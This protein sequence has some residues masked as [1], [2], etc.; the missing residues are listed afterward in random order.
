MTALK[1]TFRAKW[2]V[3]IYLVIKITFVY[4]TNGTADAKLCKWMFVYA[5]ITKAGLAHNVAAAYP[6]DEG[7]ETKKTS[8]AGQSDHR[9]QLDRHICPCSV[10][11]CIKAL[12][13]YRRITL[14]EKRY[15]RISSKYTFRFIIYLNVIFDKTFHMAFCTIFQSLY[16]I[17]TSVNT[18]LSGYL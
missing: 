13:E 16:F 8:V 18:F 7:S 6:F 9:C 12:G 10:M 5:L 3:G 1:I 11:V 4:M 15:W 17:Y 2:R 14:K